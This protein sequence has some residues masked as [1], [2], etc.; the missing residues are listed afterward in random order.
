LFA[1]GGESRFLVYPVEYKGHHHQHEN[2]AVKFSD[3]FRHEA[4]EIDV[5]SGWLRE[6]SGGCPELLSTLL[7][8]DFCLCVE[9]DEHVILAGSS[10]ADCFEVDDRPPQTFMFRSG[11]RINRVSNDSHSAMP[12]LDHVTFFLVNLRK[13]K[14]VDFVHFRY[15]FI[16]LAHHLGVSLSHHDGSESK[17]IDINNDIN[18]NDI[19]NDINNN[20]IN[21][22]I[23][24]NDINNNNNSNDIN[25]NNNSNNI[26]FNVN[27]KRSNISRNLGNIFSILSIKNQRIFS[28]KI[29]NDSFQL[30][31]QFGR[32][33][34]SAFE[35]SEQFVKLEGREAQR[36]DSWGR[37]GVHGLALKLIGH[38]SG[39]HGGLDRVPGPY[40]ILEHLHIWKHQIFPD[41]RVLLRLVAAPIILST[42]PR[43]QSLVHALDPL[44]LPNQNSFLVLLNRASDWSVE[45]V[46]NSADLR[47]VG[48]MRDNWGR[49]R[50][51]SSSLADFDATWLLLER[52]YATNPCNAAIRRLTNLL[53]QSPQQLTDSPF[54]DPLNF[55][56]DPSISPV[57]SR[58]CPVSWNY[59]VSTDRIASAN[60]LFDSN[61]GPSPVKFFSRSHQNQISHS[62]R[63]VDEDAEQENNSS[64]AANAS[65][66]DR[67]KWVNV[68]FHPTLPLILIYQ[69]GIFRSMFVK[70]MYN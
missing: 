47:L 41:G 37:P 43:H 42:N 51:R 62:I 4:I 18:N 61:Y 56:W 58:A 52:S 68:I 60:G 35:D 38:L 65:S 25:N 22:D 33:S 27:S 1:F 20:D 32:N 26:N 11:N 15:D 63:F 16:Y 50:G 19:N 48:W 3:F 17:E 36:D 23:S 49:L 14:V 70:I 34:C 5:V 24:N 21:D 57:L 67:H 55:R 13:M 12:A 10:P 53:P 31:N 44:P 28:F 2:E 66:M 46:F 8:R 9:G 29:E 7:C 39:Q 45:A 6:V 64:N 69:Y 59:F 54:L 30:V 40:S